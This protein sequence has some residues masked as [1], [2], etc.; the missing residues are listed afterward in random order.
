MPSVPVATARRDPR[1]NPLAHLRLNP[2][3]RASGQRAIIDPG[4]F[5][6]C[7]FGIRPEADRDQPF[8]PDALV[9]CL[10]DPA[11]CSWANADSAPGRRVRSPQPSGNH[12]SGLS[13]SS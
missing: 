6:E 12:E 1:T 2:A 13:S 11:K 3:D 9:S 4:G 5:R 7:H 10:G 8:D